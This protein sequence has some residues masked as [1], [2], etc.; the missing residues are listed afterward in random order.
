MNNYKTKNF[1][2]FSGGYNDTVHN[3]NL[4]ENEFSEFYNVTPLPNGGFRVR[5]GTKQLNQVAF[6][7]EITQLIEWKLRNGATKTLVISGRRMYEFSSVLGEWSVIKYNNAEL[8]LASDTV[9]YTF[10]RDFFYFTDG[11]TMYQWDDTIFY[12]SNLD[13]YEH[14]FKAGDII[15]LTVSKQESLFRG[16]EGII[17]DVRNRMRSKISYPYRAYLDKNE[18]VNKDAYQVKYKFVNIPAGKY[19]IDETSDDNEENGIYALRYSGFSGGFYGNL[20]KDGIF[21]DIRREQQPF[22]GNFSY[23]EKDR[24]ND[25]SQSYIYLQEYADGFSKQHEMYGDVRF[26]HIGNV[27]EYYRFNVD[28]EDFYPHNF[29]YITHE[30]YLSANGVVYEN[31]FTKLDETEILPNI[32]AVVEIPKEILA[33][34]YFCFYGKRQ[35]FLASGNPEDPTAVYV[36]QIGTFEKWDDTITIYPDYN[37]GVVTGLRNMNG[38]ILICFENGFTYLDSELLIAEGSEALVEYIPRISSVPIGCSAGNTLCTVPEGIVF[39]HNENIFLAA[40]SLF[41]KNYV[42]MPSQNEFVCLSRNKCENILKGST[43]HRAI[44][45]DHKY[46]LYFLDAE[47]KDRILIYD[48]R[49][50][51]FLLY[52]DV[53]ISGFISKDKGNHLIV[54]SGKYVLSAFQEGVYTDSVGGTSTAISFSVR[55]KFFDLGY[56]YRRLDLKRLYLVMNSYQFGDAVP[57]TNETERQGEIQFS[58]IGDCQNQEIL[59]NMKDGVLWKNAKWGDKYAWNNEFVIHAFN[60]NFTTNRIGFS[61]F[62]TE[63]TKLNAP[64]IFFNVSLVYSKLSE[65]VTK[66]QDELLN[67]SIPDF[68]HWPDIRE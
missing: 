16:D 7:G 40:F 59:N 68:Q 56:D 60:L 39:Y 52:G 9:A 33:C 17:M 42:K 31:V 6:P 36:S 57:V 49:E 29:N 53:P 47:T 4:K 46:Y 48:F 32:K 64:L 50:G 21:Y 37:L 61:I 27:G 14:R 1:F 54:S 35:R 51:H 22:Y 28:V 18:Y 25:G 5:N 23:G 38:D 20:A 65:D 11:E 2:D 41:G 55:S 30:K 58:L 3:L 19:E 26:E 8:E 24:L 62:N 15:K 34:Q 43:K 63:N 66:Y 44:Y 12:L 10:F 67:Q 13:E 45:H